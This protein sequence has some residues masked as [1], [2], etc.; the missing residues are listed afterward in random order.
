LRI[1]RDLSGLLR[2]GLPG[3]ERKRQQ[4]QPCSAQRAAHCGADGIVRL[5]TDCA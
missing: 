1:L 4:C 3:G 5:R 2:T